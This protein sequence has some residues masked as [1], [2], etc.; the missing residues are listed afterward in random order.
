[1]PDISQ[2]GAAS[3]TCAAS[4]PRLPCLLGLVASI[5][6][7]PSMASAD[8]LP[9]SVRSCATEADPSRRLACYDQEVARYPEAPPRI[10]AKTKPG[11]NQ[12][13]TQDIAR[14]EPRH[15]TARVVSLEGSQDSLVVHLDNGQVWEQV[16]DA[17]ADMN[18]SAGSTITID[19]SLGSY[20][21]GG[22]SAGVMKVEQ[23][24]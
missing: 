16:Q 4:P 15:V 7:F 11:E 6:A 19:K 17:T 14:T 24:K 12:R 9:A 23:K 2:K 3:P 10:D 13:A 5:L 20:W 21:L 22:R 8:S 1:M 18:L